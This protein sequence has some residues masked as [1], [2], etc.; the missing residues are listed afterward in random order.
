MMMVVL[1]MM[2]MQ[3]RMMQLGVHTEIMTSSKDGGATQM[4][5]MLVMMLFTLPMCVTY[6]LG[7]DGDYDDCDDGL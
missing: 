6:A 5:T 3:T 7:A 4:V 2:K 1:L